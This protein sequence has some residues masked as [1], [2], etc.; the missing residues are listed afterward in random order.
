MINNYGQSL[1][2]VIQ[3]F[4][5][6]IELNRL[7]TVKKS[8]MEV[9]FVCSL[10][11]FNG[12]ILK[13][14]PVVEKMR[15]GINYSCYFGE[16][17]KKILMLEN[18]AEMLLNISKEFVNTMLSTVREWNGSKKDKEEL[19]VPLKL[20]SEVEEPIEFVSQYIVVNETGYPIEIY[21]SQLELR[22]RV[23]TGCQVGYNVEM[24]SCELAD[25][26]VVV[27]VRILHPRLKLKP[28]EKIN[29]N[30]SNTLRIFPICESISNFSCGVMLRPVF[31]NQTKYYYITSSL[32][33][34]DKTA[35]IPRD[36]YLPFDQN[37]RCIQFTQPLKLELSLDRLRKGPHE[38]E[39]YR[40]SLT[41][42]SSDHYF[43]TITITHKYTAT[44]L[45]PV[46]IN[47]N[48]T[49]L[50]PRKSTGFRG[51]LLINGEKSSRTHYKTFQKQNEVFIYCEA[52]YI[53]YY[54]LEV[55][56]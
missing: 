24:D 31:R 56:T 25:A 42:L 12:S 28:I 11:Y 55:A 45:L 17:I 19:P 2:P 37:L 8:I 21:D 51:D 5:E 3:L 1:V 49:L 44:N 18:T 46:A 27:S 15:V 6:E 36:Y 38:Q 30:S 43:C 47:V 41:S 39:F 20:E 54:G 4:T 29:L 7:L 50:Q 9:F 53:D 16:R 32:H 22:H 10:N 33:I 48:G 35:D 52:Y 14:E 13:W 40:Y 26:D 23:D 34:V